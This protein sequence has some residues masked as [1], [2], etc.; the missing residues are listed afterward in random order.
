MRDAAIID[1][2]LIEISSIADDLMKFERIVAWCTT[3][4]DEVP[5]AMKILMNRTNTTQP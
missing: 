5:F 1:E 4:P 3:H 2:D